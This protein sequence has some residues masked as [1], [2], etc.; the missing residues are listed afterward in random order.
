MMFWFL[1]QEAFHL[2][3]RR[4][5]LYNIQYSINS[6]SEDISWVSFF[7]FWKTIH[8]TFNTVNNQSLPVT[9]G[10]WYLI[11]KFWLKHLCI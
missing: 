7:L 2:V 9:T 3:Q 1:E 5:V 8:E 4:I 6:E 11:L 10:V